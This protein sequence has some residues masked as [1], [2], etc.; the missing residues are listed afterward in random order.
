MTVKE[1]LDKKSGYTFDDLVSIMKILRGEDGCPWDREQDHRSIRKNLIEETYEVVE[2]IDNDDPTLMCEE[3]GD[4]ILQAVFHA[5]MAD[6]EGR[7]NIDDVCNGICEK[8]IV[9]HPHIFADTVADSSEEVLKNWDYIKQQ[10]KH[11]KTV[12]EKL[13][14]I[15]PSLPALMRAYKA[16]EKAAKVGFDFPTAESAVQKI[17]EELAE[18]EN[19]SQ[20]DFEEEIGDLLFSVVN[21]A[22]KRGIDPEESLYKATDKFINRFS[23]VENE[24]ISSGKRMEQLSMDELDAIWDGI[25]HQK[26]D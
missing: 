19:A 14:S 17:H 26:A 10:T 8:L 18:V 2:A 15:P 11:Q 21:V 12:S 20:N 1:L 5:Q 3:L 16:G 22:R 25:K 7:F 24:V 6:E 13:N 9:R 23:R 4:L